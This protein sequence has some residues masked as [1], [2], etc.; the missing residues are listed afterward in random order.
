[1][2]RTHTLMHKHTLRR[3]THTHAPHTCIDPFSP[4]SSTAPSFINISTPDTHTHTLFKQKKGI[5]GQRPRT[6][7]HTHLL[8]AQL[9]CSPPLCEPS[10]YAEGGRQRS[11][12]HRAALHF[13]AKQLTFKQL[14]T[15]GSGFLF[16]PD[17]TELMC[18]NLITFYLRA[19]SFTHL[20]LLFSSASCY[21]FL[22][23]HYP[24]LAFHL[25]P[26]VSLLPV[27]FY[28]IP[29]SSPP[30]PPS[31]PPYHFY[32]SVPLCASLPFS[33]YSTSLSSSF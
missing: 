2:Q 14:A 13:P 17:G 32:I 23:P 16:F 3:N 28:Y 8:F 18:K 1:M 24:P 9:L 21:L 15:R 30:S 10:K 22:S 7:T 11:R 25:H 19:L 4:E 27:H 5:A 33:L 29:P 31:L 12:G 20:L 6:H 26:T